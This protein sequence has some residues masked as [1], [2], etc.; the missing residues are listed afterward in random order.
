VCSKKNLIPQRAI[1]A[2]GP[3]HLLVVGEVEEVLAEIL[4]GEPVRAG[5]E[6]LGELADGGDVTL[7]C[8]GREPSEL[9]VLG[10]PLA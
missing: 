9:H 2:V 8:A 5:V 4:L 6:M 7:L 1:V 3:G 10:H